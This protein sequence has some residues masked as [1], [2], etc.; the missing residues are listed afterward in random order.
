MRHIGTNLVDTA[1][2]IESRVSLVGYPDV[3]G[4]QVA[5]LG[6]FSRFPHPKGPEEAL[7]D[8]RPMV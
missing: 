1:S 5:L 3:R 8:N 2:L 6:A 7:A 4:R